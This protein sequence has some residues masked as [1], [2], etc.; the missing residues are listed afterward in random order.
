MEKTSDMNGV[1]EE[2]R[3]R[4]F[5]YQKDTFSLKLI[6]FMCQNMTPSL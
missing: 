6:T 4:N 3:R 2:Y 1:A 5:E